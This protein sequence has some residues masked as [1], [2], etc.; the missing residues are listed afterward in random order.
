MAQLFE[1]SEEDW[2]ARTL[3]AQGAP[4]YHG[5]SDPEPALAGPKVIP[6]NDPSRQFMGWALLWTP[7]LPVWLNGQ[8]TGT[9]LHVLR[10]RDE[11]RIGDRPPVFFSE[12]ELPVVV[13]FPEL[14]HDAF[15]TR[16]QM[17]L[18]PGTDVVKCPGQKCG[19]HFYHAQAGGRDCFNYGPCLICGYEPAAAPTFQWTPKEVYS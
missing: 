6:F 16:C 10:H 4:L 1:F 18:E 13:P 2:V 11:I 9:G 3:S 15:C 12:E 5:N 7:H 17:K 8:R 19:G 14:D